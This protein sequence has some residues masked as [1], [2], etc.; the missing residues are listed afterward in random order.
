VTDYERYRALYLAPLE[1]GV[2]PPPPPVGSPVLDLRCYYMPAGQSE[3]PELSLPELYTSG[4]ECGHR[5]ARAEL[6]RRIDIASVQLQEFNAVCEQVTS[7]RRQLASQLVETQRIV[8]E[9]DKERLGAGT[10]IRNLESSLAAARARIDELEASHTWRATEP[11]RRGGHRLKLLVARA[12]AR[13]ATL[14]GSRRYVG[15]ALTVLRQE[16]VRALARRVWRRLR[17]HYRFAPTG[18][19]VFVAEAMVQPLEFIAV[20]KPGATI[21]IPVHGHALL[22]YTC[23]KSVRENT[24]AGVYEVVVVDDASP[25]PT[26]VALS[27]VKGVR[28][29]RNEA[30]R[31][32][33]AS[34]NR[35]AKL[36]RGE[37]IVFLNN[38][39]IVTPGWLDALTSLLRER[40]D[41]GLVGAKLIYPDGRLQEAGGLVWRDGSAWNYGRGDDPDKPEYNYAREADYCSGAC[42]AV[43]RELFE[44]IGG[45]DSRFAPAYYEDTDLAFAVRA[46]GRKVYYQP[47]ATVVHFEGGTGGTDPTSGAKRY[48][49]V[50]QSA[51]VAKWET[52]LARHRPNGLAPGLERDRQA[53]YR[54][55]VIDA[56]M[57]TP[58]RDSG[59]LRMR[60]ILDILVSLG[61]KVTFIADNLEHRQPYVAS[62]QRAGVEVQFHP[63]VRSIADFLA[64]HGADFD[65][66]L[67]SR[68]YVA[69]KHLD[70]VRDLVPDALTVFDTVD[71]HFRRAERLAEL[72]GS[73]LARIATRATRDEE[74][75]LM[76]RADVTLVVSHAEQEL[77]ERIE[78]RA[79]VM[80]LSNIHET[81]E[82]G[83][84]FDEREGL[85]FIGGFRHPP[86]V[87]A[88]L[89]YAAEVRPLVRERLPGVKTY[90]IGDDA[91]PTLKELADDD[92]VFTGYVPDVAPYLSGCRLSISP[93]RYGAGVKGKVNQAMSYGLPV[94]AT[95]PSIE[96]MQLTPGFDVLVGDT[97]EA[98]ADAVA[99]AYGDRV[100]WN[101]LADGG[102]ENVRAHFSREA[103]LRAV[104]RLI[105]LVEERRAARSD[106]A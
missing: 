8:S 81:R 28:F 56:C 48:Q 105:T 84:P 2:R 40:P 95:T 33:V 68:H 94:V 5:E 32:F 80:V 31:G 69:A 82:D 12:R 37:V 85:V 54:V 43:R 16:G 51:F 42:L 83:K 97:P 7:A 66:V 74:L 50:N 63:Y 103:A 78:P 75:S 106:A 27:E 39:T 79:R 87:D 34:C 53:K 14:R 55:L 89:W 86:N 104:T 60:E 76:R 41:A 18:S 38:D 77:L 100:L 17:R 13:W 64:G 61:C 59:S 92:F 47:F 26:E 58:D 91:S 72:N 73:A 25:Q 52:V 99:R 93:L 71:L 22:T 44:Q 9:R 15:L 29:V 23:L 67:M 62:L 57:L 90:V 19:R 88:I 49:V 102:R 46:A 96:G 21:V 11:L 20:D 3:R 65:L 101:A 45:F 35:A 4:V 6:K 36:A 30:N 1:A 98:F 24:P 10:H 70:N